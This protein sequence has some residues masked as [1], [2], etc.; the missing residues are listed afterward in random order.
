MASPVGPEVGGDVGVEV[1]VAVVQGQGQREQEA[2]QATRQPSPVS[3]EKIK[4]KLDT[5]RGQL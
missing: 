5:H 2:A 4:R 1:G 3:R